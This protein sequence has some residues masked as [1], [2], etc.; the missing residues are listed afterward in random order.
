M[1]NAR[2]DTKAVKAGADGVSLMVGPEG[3]DRVEM[4]AEL[5]LVATGRAPNGEG[6]ALESTRAELERGFVKVDARMRTKEPHLYSIGDAIGGL[7]LAHTSA[8][9][10]I[11][12]ASI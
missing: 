10:G 2:F 9:E 5:L 7:M 12:T 1:T 6:G 4:Q 11:L 3:K 8:Y